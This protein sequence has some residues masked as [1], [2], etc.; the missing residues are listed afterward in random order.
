M[1]DE[2]SVKYQ[3]LGQVGAM[4][5][6]AQ[7]SQLSQHQGSVSKDESFNYQ[8]LLEK[9]LELRSAIDEESERPRDEKDAAIS[10]IQNAKDEVLAKNPS[11]VLTSL[12][13]AGP[14]L[15][16]LIEKFGIQF[17]AEEAVKHVG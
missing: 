10:V 9:L 7:V 13:K 4:G 16:S 15:T 1:K 8:L 2:A 3:N 12:R 6:N 14:W 11:G 17:L 5:D